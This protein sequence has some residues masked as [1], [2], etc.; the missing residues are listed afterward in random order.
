MAS[1][2]IKRAVA[3]ISTSK[4]E[5]YV[6]EKPRKAVRRSLGIN[7]C[8][9]SFVAGVGYV[10]KGQLKVDQ[11]YGLRA[12]ATRN[13]QLLLDFSLSILARNFSTPF[14]VSAYCRF[15]PWKGS[16][17]RSFNKT[18]S[19]KPGLLLLLDSNNLNRCM[20]VIGLSLGTSLSVDMIWS[21]D[22]HSRDQNPPPVLLLMRTLIL[23]LS[24]TAI[25]AVNS[26]LSEMVRN[27]DVCSIFREES[28][29]V[30]LLEEGMVFFLIDF[31]GAAFLVVDF[32][33][34]SILL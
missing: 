28:S 19:K 2:N 31:F 33:V 34:I 21:K 10:E 3:P 29:I 9:L 13:H 16:T 20:E 27:L 30:G 17:S 4:I 24:S 11:L 26:L 5:R 14:L 32:L 8:L 15:F 1:A 6:K 25:L 18:A 22:T 12:K 7:W 23:P